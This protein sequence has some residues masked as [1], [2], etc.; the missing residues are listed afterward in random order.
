[1]KQSH[2]RE[3]GF[4]KLVVAGVVF[5]ALSLFL[6]I[7]TP[8]SNFGAVRGNGGSGAGE[9]DGAQPRAV[10]VNVGLPERVVA[11][12]REGEEIAR[13]TVEIA[14]TSE[15]QQIGLMG[16]TE[17]A[18]D[19]GML[20]VW[21]PPTIV[22]MWMKDTFI[23]LDFVYVRQGGV[24]VDLRHDVPPCEPGGHCPAYAANE[25]VAYVLE[26][27]GGRAQELGLLPGDRLVFVDGAE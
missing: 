18:P 22:A 27:A 19:R 7:M 15:T 26:I 2:K 3:S 17:L 1:M 11:I 9:G 16:R 21:H 24:I 12:Q 13:F 25:P 14:D 23:P 6:W 4:G 5:A 20:F 8:W 10:R